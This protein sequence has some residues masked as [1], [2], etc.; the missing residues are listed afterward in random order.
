[1]AYS[2]ND[3]GVGANAVEDPGGGAPPL[4]S[5]NSLESPLNWLKKSKKSWAPTFLQILDVPLNRV[6]YSNR[7][8]PNQGRAGEMFCNIGV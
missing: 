6:K 1:M 3:C 8:A 4:F 2:L 7:P 5:P